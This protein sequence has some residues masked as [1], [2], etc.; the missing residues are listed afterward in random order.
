[1]LSATEFCGL[2]ILRMFYVLHG[3]RSIIYYIV[4]PRCSI[5]HIIHLILWPLWA[6]LVKKIKKYQIHYPLPLV[7]EV[8]GGRARYPY[9]LYCK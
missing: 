1:M 3:V 2:H 6:I 8:C 7:H 9:I 4:L 5:I